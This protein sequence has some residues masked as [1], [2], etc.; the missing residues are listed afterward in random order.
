MSSGEQIAF[1]SGCF[2]LR[3]P[4]RA[5]ADFS[6]YSIQSEQGPLIDGHINAQRIP[7]KV[8]GIII[9]FCK[10]CGG[11]FRTVLY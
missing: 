9:D 7:S 5:T 8:A 3:K 11:S 1:V 6:R 10:Q 4:R 2:G